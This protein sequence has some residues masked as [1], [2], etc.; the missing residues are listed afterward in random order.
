M[1]KNRK[2]KETYITISAIIAIA[3]LLGSFNLIL[4]SKNFYYYNYEKESYGKLYD[5]GYGEFAVLNE[6]SAKAITNNLLGFFAGADKLDYFSDFEKS[7]LNDVRNV[8]WI[9]FGIYF[10]LILLIILFL[11]CMLKKL[12]KKHAKLMAIKLILKKSAFFTS[13]LIILLSVVFISF[14]Y[15]FDL[16]HK[17]FFPMGNWMFPANSLLITLFPEIFFIRFFALVLFI[18][19]IKALVVFVAAKWIR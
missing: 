7:H 16:F 1:T 14:N 12:I 18:T 3:F 2:K 9:V 19:F 4:F 5:K 15:F 8:I 11:L 13:G 10:V 6:I 17:I